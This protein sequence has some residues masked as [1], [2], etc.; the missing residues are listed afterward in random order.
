[1]RSS[2]VGNILAKNEPSSYLFTPIPLDWCVAN[3]QGSIG[4]ILLDALDHQLRQAGIAARS[5]AVVTRTVVPADP[6][7]DHPTKPIGRFADA[8]TAERLTA[9]GQHWVQSDKGRRRV[10][11]SPEP[12]EIVDA[13]A[14]DALLKAGFLVIGAGG[15]GIPVIRE[16]DGSLTGIEAVIDK[17]LTS[18]LLARQVRADALVIATNVT[19]PGSTG[20]R[21]APD[22][23]G[24][25]APTSCAATTRPASS[26]PGRWGPRSR[27]PCASSRPAAP[28][29]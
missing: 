19:R 27:P 20:A 4:Y 21:T 15:G 13:D 11:P 2:Q 14:V 24:G 23:S 29:R 7:F 5:V 26:R 1:M 9:F 28:R 16:Q 10:V 25:S 8:D 17:D 22:R 12:V 18:V 6:A 3:T